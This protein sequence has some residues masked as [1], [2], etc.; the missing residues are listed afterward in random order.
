VPL[1]LLSFV[2]AICFTWSLILA[3]TVRAAMDD[4]PR[5]LGHT[6]SLSSK[7]M[8]QITGARPVAGGGDGGG[9]G[10]TGSSG[11]TYTTPAATPGSPYPWEGA[12]G[13]V[14]VGNGNK[15]TSVAIVG[16]TERGSLPI[17]LTLNH[18]SESTRNGELGPKW[19]MSYDSTMSVD[20]SGNVTVFWGDGRVYTFTK[21]MDGTYAPPPGIHDILTQI[22]A[23]Q[24]TA[25]PF[26]NLKAKDQTVFSF[27]S[28][29]Q[30][31]FCLSAINDENHNFIGVSH[32]AGTNLVKYISDNLGRSVKLAY[33]N[34]LLTS[35]TDPL[36]R[37]WTLNYDGSGRLTHVYWPVI[38]GATYSINLG[39]DG[40]G[41]ISSFQDKN[42]NT[43]TFAYN[44]VSTPSVG[45]PIAW[46][47]DPYGN[48]TTFTYGYDGV[49]ATSNASVTTVT[50]ANNHSTAYYITSNGQVSTVYDA[51]GNSTSFTYDTANNVT[52]K[53]DQ[54]G[55][56]W[57]AYYDSMGNVLTVT[58]PGDST[59]ILTYTTHNKLQTEQ[60]PSGRAVGISYDANDNPIE[61]QQ[62]DASGNV[63]STETF[64]IGSYGL[65]SDKYDPNNHHTNYTY[66]ANG[67]LNSTTTPLGNKT[68]WAY[69][70]LGFQTSRT[71]AMGRTTNY[72]PDAWERLVTT[73][74]PDS[75]VHNFAYDANGNLT[76]WAD[77]G[78]GS[79][80]RTYDADNRMLSEIGYGT[81]QVSHTYDGSGQ[82][83][84]LSTTADGFGRTLSYGYTARNEMS[85]ISEP[86]GV[87]SY[88]Y[89]P[90]GNQ[91]SVYSQGHHTGQYYNPDGTLDSLYNY[92]SYG[93]GTA[94]FSSYGYSYTADHQISSFTEGQSA[95]VHSTPNPTQTA[96]GYDAQ[97]RLTAE[98]RTGSS[99]YTYGYGYDPAGNRT[100]K[101][102]NGTGATQFYDSDDELTQINNPASLAFGYNAN[103][104]QTAASANGVVTN[105]GYDYDDQLV[106]LSR[107]GYT[108][109]YGY[110][111]LGRQVQRTAGG[112]ATVY[113]FDGASVLYETQ[114]GTETGAYTWRNGLVRRNGEWALLDGLGS[115]RQMTDGGQNVTS[116]SVLTAYGQTVGVSGSTSCG[117]T[118][119]GSA[120]YRTDSEDGP[121]GQQRH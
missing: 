49:H 120:G 63:A 86:A 103:G 115:A 84:L 64:T 5:P 81:T 83:G 77:P 95:N 75:S 37:Q 19:L 17:N 16:W 41:N 116:A 76:G 118:F 13:G 47:Q 4:Q 40:G 71:D 28:G 34:N 113:H 87:T 60:L 6:R 74:Y 15:L 25:Q 11:T 45:N 106:S 46:E 27:Y 99:A 91:F 66:D 101:T 90:D 104:D 62:F 67:Y 107:P 24:G 112:T 54:R 12:V 82:K 39:Y 55:Y 92:S 72:T 26:Y 88:A 105:F 80:G 33:T 94:V 30:G 50:D 18:N 14:K 78:T 22:P 61:V 108:A 58:P 117:Y 48:R 8:S 29:S 56:K 59:S 69:D 109:S 52:Q 10:G 57:T 98:T 93:Q 110:D 102:V 3:S 43:S 9:S 31:L 114:G 1:R 36:N 96:Y 20:G 100:S 68:Q 89:D 79:W 38:N 65:V 73:T 121:A 32:I 85:I 53:T 7:E 51:L 23:G 97:G 2:T 44:S 21:N 119:Q 111:A 35:V 42:G 70:A